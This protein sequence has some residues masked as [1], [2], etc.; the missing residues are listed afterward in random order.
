MP[1]IHDN[2]RYM[3]EST[4]IIGGLEQKHSGVALSPEDVDERN[5]ALELVA[6]SGKHLDHDLRRVAYWYILPD[7][8][9]TR[10]LLATGLS[11]WHRR[12]CV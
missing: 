2:G 8:H 7:T 10:E 1:M 12:V 6:E 4:G 5:H 3:N 9:K 11:S